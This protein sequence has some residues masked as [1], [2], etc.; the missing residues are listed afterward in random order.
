[1]RAALMPC[2]EWP[3][4][5][6]RSISYSSRTPTPSQ[7]LVD[8]P[9]KITGIKRHVINTKWVALTDYTV[10]SARNARQASLTKAWETAGVLAKWNASAW[11]KKVAARAAKVTQTDFQR[12]QVKVAKQA[13]SK[14]VRAALAA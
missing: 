6:M 3:H 1:M 8:G 10:P 9:T 5:G 13:I 2:I 7:L 4:T 12:F 11:G 14:K